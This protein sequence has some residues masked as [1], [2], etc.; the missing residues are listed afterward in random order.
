VAL[1]LLL[2]YDPSKRIEAQAG[3]GHAP[4]P[5]PLAAV[6]SM[7]GLGRPVAGGPTFFGSDLLIKGN[8]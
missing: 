3:E 1:N 5:P 2:N 6:E 7:A 4:I 8:P